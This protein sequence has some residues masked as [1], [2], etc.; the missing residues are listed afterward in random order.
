M[1]GLHIMKLV[2]SFCR[3]S[4][5]SA[6]NALSSLFTYICDSDSFIFAFISLSSFQ[7]S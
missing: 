3:S 6:G 2:R 4:G 7:S 5:E 1:R